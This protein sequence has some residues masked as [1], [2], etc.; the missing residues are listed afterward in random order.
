MGQRRETGIEER[1]NSIRLSFQWR[2]TR[3]RETINIPPTKSNMQYAAGLRAEIRRKIELGTFNY[4]DYFPESPKAQSGVKKIP[5]F[6]DAADTWLKSNRQLA[7][8]S[9]VTYEKHLNKHWRPEFGK[10]RID[11]ITYTEL[12]AHLSDIKVAPKTRNNILIPMRRI[13]DA[14]FLDGV[15][16]TNPAAR[17]RNVKAQRPEPDPFTILELD[18]ILTHIKIYLR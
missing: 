1:G 7:K 3:C 12:M 2:G 10:R 15:I 8:S 6:G 14:A 16:A 11:E 5:T 18:L 9:D 13:L 17:I 4:A